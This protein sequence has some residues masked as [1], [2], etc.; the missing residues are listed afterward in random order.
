MIEIYLPKI[1]DLWFREKLMLDAETMSYNERWGGTIPFPE[2]KWADWYGFWVVNHENKR[3]YRYLKDNE[4]N[5]FVGEVAYHY[6]EEY[7]MYILDV[8]I[9]SKFRGIGYGKQGL[10]LLLECAKNNGINVVYDN[11]AVDNTAIK[12]FLKCGFY[13][14]F[15]TEDAIFLKKEL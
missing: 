8:I 13:E 3:F 9:Y 12:L 1:E 11:I 10:M 7:K 14:D 5:E 4:S 6:D 2:S 15:R